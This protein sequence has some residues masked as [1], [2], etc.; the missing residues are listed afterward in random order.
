MS[1]YTIKKIFMAKKA[2]IGDNMAS[3]GADDRNAGKREPSVEVVR[4]VKQ[5]ARAYKS[6]RR[7]PDSLGDIIP[8]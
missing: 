2:D 8:N 3:S 7:L 1:V 6:E 5:F 4:F